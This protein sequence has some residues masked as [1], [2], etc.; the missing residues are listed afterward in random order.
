MRFEFKVEVE[1]ERLQGKFASRDE[2]EQAITDALHDANPAQFDGLGADG[3][4][5]YEVSGWEVEPV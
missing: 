2:I 5:E 4:S 3:D 1:V